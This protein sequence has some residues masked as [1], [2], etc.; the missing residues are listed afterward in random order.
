MTS[1]VQVTLDVPEEGAGVESSTLGRRG[2]ARGLYEDLGFPECQG[3]S[4]Y[5]TGGCCGKRRRRK[6]GSR[7]H[8]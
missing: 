8:W 4:R 3:V 5:P 1:W 7:C 6:P 2:A